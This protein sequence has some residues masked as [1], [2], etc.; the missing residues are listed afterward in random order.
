MAHAISTT[1]PTRPDDL[2]VYDP[3]RFR[4]EDGQWKI[5]ERVIRDWSGPV[6]A[7]IAGQT[8]EREG[9]PLPPPLAGLVYDTGQ[10]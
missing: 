9:R 6:L 5:A 2:L 7:A 4:R 8:G 3:H 1:A 10:A